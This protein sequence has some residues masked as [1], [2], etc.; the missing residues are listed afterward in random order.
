MHGYVDGTEVKT[1]LLKKLSQRVGILSRVRRFM[2][3]HR[4]GII[5]NGL[6]NSKLIYGISV[7]G[8]V[9]NL[10]GVLDEEKRNSRL[11]GIH[12]TAYAH[13]A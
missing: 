13:A 3:E 2:N 1:G 8:G 6:F 11:D 5:A 10:P 9:W 4:F 7:W 12:Q